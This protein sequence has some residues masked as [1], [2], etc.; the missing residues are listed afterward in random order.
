MGNAESET[1]QI[2]RAETK[3]A[4]R[5][6]AAELHIDALGIASWP[7]PAETIERWREPDPCPFTTGTAEERYTGGT[8]LKNPQSAIVCLF[9]YY[10]Q[11]PPEE[12]PSRGA[13]LSANL[14]LTPYEPVNLAAYTWGEDYHLT[15]PRYLQQL[16]AFLRRSHPNEEYEIHCDTS[17]LVDRFIAWQAGL[18]FPGQNRFLIHPVYGT[19][20]HIGTI[21]TSL[22]LEPDAPLEQTC[23]S[24]GACISACP[25]QSLGHRY[26][27]YSTC[28][29]Y[30]TQR[31]GILTPVEQDILRQ[32][33][34]IWGCD[35]CQEV[36]PH[37]RDVPDTTIPEFQDISPFLN[38]ADLTGLT[39][40]EFKSQFG[41]RAFSWRGPK[42]LLRNHAYL[43]DEGDLS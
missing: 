14:A 1:N 41:H 6:F 9:P 39:N 38:P 22:K 18:G 27:G 43:K 30:L 23:L 25:G 2:S 17:P 37:N 32:S 7:L 33:P 35:I 13:K 20:T 3:G 16:I 21:L 12:S 31:K 24:C 8:A 10:R 29:S 36:C 19:Y 40:R 4:L 28:K 26:F 34:L 11:L 15:V 42:V 5:R